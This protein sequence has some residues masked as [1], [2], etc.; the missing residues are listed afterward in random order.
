MTFRKIDSSLHNR[1]ETWLHDSGSS[2]VVAY[3]AVHNRLPVFRA[4]RA[5]N[6]VPAG[7]MP[8][9]I[10]N[11]RIGPEDGFLSLEQAMRAVE[12]FP[13]N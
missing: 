10:D 7:R 12:A 9:T 13:T 11:K 4:Y 3:P 5:I 6:P 2:W 8:W 1:Q